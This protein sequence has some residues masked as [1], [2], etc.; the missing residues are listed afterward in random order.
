[1]QMES[2][3]NYSKTTYQQYTYVHKE[4]D[5]HIVQLPNQEWHFN[6]TV[7]HAWDWSEMNKNVSRKAS[8]DEAT[9]DA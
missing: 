6:W 1:M 4:H 3:K 7:Q 5:S 2:I 9:M 8:K